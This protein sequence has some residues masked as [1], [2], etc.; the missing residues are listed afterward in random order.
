MRPVK[1]RLESDAIR[2]VPCDQAAERS[3]NGK[4]GNHPADGNQGITL[5]GVMNRQIGQERLADKCPGCHD[6]PD[7]DDR[8][9]DRSKHFADGSDQPEIL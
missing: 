1:H 4:K 3:G 7:Q 6:E 2:Q 5:S 9:P 8:L